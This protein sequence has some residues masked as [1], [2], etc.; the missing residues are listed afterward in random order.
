[1][2]QLV[3]RGSYVEATLASKGNAMPPGAE[4]RLTEALQFVLARPL[5]WSVAERYNDSLPVYQIQAVDSQPSEGVRLDRRVGPG[6]R[7]H[8]V[9][10]RRTRLRLHYDRR[11]DGR[12]LVHHAS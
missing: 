6:V 1:M 8:V 11:T 5:R 3:A 4:E 7:R 12:H 10:S 2:L 9:R